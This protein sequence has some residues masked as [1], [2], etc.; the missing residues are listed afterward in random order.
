MFAVFGSLEVH[1]QGEPTLEGGAYT[2]MVAKGWRS[3]GVILEASYHLS[4]YRCLFLSTEFPSLLLSCLSVSWSNF[5]VSAYRPPWFLQQCVAF[6]SRL[7]AEQSLDYITQS[8]IDGQLGYLLLHIYFTGV[9]MLLES[10]FLQVEL[11]G[12]RVCARHI[13]MTMAK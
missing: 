4:S 10:K 6:P 13:L 9:R 1:H 11:L 5:Q 12:Q 8:L 3:V 2:G 7:H